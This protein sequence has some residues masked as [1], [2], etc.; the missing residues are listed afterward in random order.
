M[1]CKSEKLINSLL[2]DKEYI[3]YMK[4][5]DNTHHINIKVLDSLLKKHLDLYFLFLKINIL[6]YKYD[7]KLLNNDLK[8]YTHYKNEKLYINDIDIIMNYYFHNYAICKRLL[9]DL[10]LY[11]LRPIEETKIIIKIINRKPNEEYSS[12]LNNNNK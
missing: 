11:N 12:I 10:A 3:E 8:D 6:L 1:I 7:T 9:K 4:M 2:K 5:C